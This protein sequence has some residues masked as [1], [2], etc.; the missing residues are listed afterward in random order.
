MF[1][2]FQKIL[3]HYFMGV[4]AIGFISSV[5]YGQFSVSISG[6]TVNTMVSPT[7][8]FNINAN[9]TISAPNVLKKIV[10]YRNDVPYKT[11]LNPGL[12]ESI[13]QDE[14]GQDTY[15]YKVRAYN[16][17]DE[18]VDSAEYKLIV[19]T[20][21]IL[22]MGKTGPGNVITH[23]T[24]ETFTGVIK[25]PSRYADHTEAIKAAIAYLN[26]K[27]GGTLYFPCS[28]GEYND[29]QS[30]Y[31]I[32][33]T[34][35]VPS[36][37]TI[38]GESSETSGTC[39]IYLNNQTA[40]GDQ[41]CRN[42]TENNALRGIPLFAVQGGAKNV[43]FRDIFLWSRT[44]GRDCTLPLNE[45]Q[46]FIEADK[47]V[48]VAL[49]GSGGNISDVIFENVSVSDFT[50]GIK[51]TTCTNSNEVDSDFNNSSS[52]PCTSNNDY[53]IRNVKIRGFRPSN[54]FRQ[55]YINAKYAYDWDI[56][57]FNINNML[58]NQGGVEIMKSGSPAVIEGENRSLKF[59][60]L[61]C[62]GNQYRTPAFCG[63]VKKHGG[64]YFRQLH[65][66]G[67][68]SALLVEDISSGDNPQTNPDP[69][70][71]EHGVATGE[72]K[73]PSMKLYLIGNSI[74]AAPQVAPAFS[75]NGRMR[76]IENG[77]N[78][79]LVDCGD[80]HGDYTDFD[81]PA[82]PRWQ[83]FHML[84]SHT[85]RNRDSFYASDGNLT[86]PKKHFVCPSNVPN[87]TDI[88]KVGGEFF[89][90]GVMPV[91]ST[92]TAN[93]IPYSYS[94]GSENCNNGNSETTCA[95]ILNKY[96]AEVDGSVPNINRGTVYIRNSVIIKDTIH[97]PHG[98][99]LFGGPN[100][101][102]IFETPDP[103][104]PLIQITAKVVD[105]YNYRTS[106]ISIRN[107]KLKTEGSNNTGLLIRGEDSTSSVGASSDLH[108][109][110]LIFEG[111]NKGM[112]VVDAATARDPMIDGLSWKNLT[113]INNQTAARIQSQN[114]SNW[115][116]MNVSIQSNA[117]NADGWYQ[118][119]GG[120]SMQNISCKGTNANYMRHCIKYDMTATYLTGFKPTEYVN[121]SL[122]FG[123]NYPNFPA[124]Y[125]ALKFGISVIRENDFR[126]INDNNVKVN[127]IG[128]TF[129]TSLNN[130][131]NTFAAG[132]TY[133]G[134]LSRVAYCGDT[135]NTS[136]FA[137]LAQ[138]YKNYYTGVPT[139]TRM[140]CGLRPK[141]WEAFINLG[142]EEEDKPFVGNFFSNVQEDIVIYREGAPS[143]FLIKS[144]D[145][146]NSTSI[147]WGL[148]ASN[149]D[150][151]DKPLVGNFIPGS[152]AQIAIWRPSTGDW[153]VYDRNCDSNNNCNP[154]GYIWHWGQEGDIPFVGNF[155]D[156]DDAYDMDEIAIYRPSSNIFWI[157]NPRTGEYR[158]IYCGGDFGTNIQVG[159]FFSGGHEQIA[160]YQVINNVGNWRIYNL[161]NTT[162]NI[163]T[164]QF[165]IAGDIPIPG[166]YLHNT[167][168][169]L[170]VWRHTI[171][172]YRWSLVA[173]ESRTRPDFKTR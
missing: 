130:K 106:G 58:A 146:K 43:R 75:D 78:A 114:L 6:P 119:T 28:G 147:D 49:Y 29:V 165:G 140:Q 23:T 164:L 77:Q 133:E 161:L 34:I 144:V 73:D 45:L 157:S 118:I 67:T 158:S 65:H 97:I 30:I 87:I 166:N 84:Y 120:N 27:G 55:L 62:N 103:T 56:Q 95:K 11:I 25:G 90:S 115:N 1:K 2:N 93:Q 74:T 134:N 31:N 79:T 141:P 122:T 128:K 53:E 88:N 143:K 15:I 54:N 137:G 139:A 170:A 5:A 162:L 35:T 39:R 163:N 63:R 150:K 91:W 38:Q 18:A 47:S 16:T 105:Q 102:L 51:A 24:P 3:L 40:F 36:N 160:Q 52:I 121:Y 149:P 136:A 19:E 81:N 113:F 46:S 37:V 153:W 167:Y 12:T 68:N 61:N 173:H 100:S 123:E 32:K 10:F 33:E 117:P 4:I 21:R 70:V 89:N 64:L 57:N 142:G 154:N 155:F 156:E 99:Q 59:L 169:Q 126:A 159:K 172:R 66:E 109:S 69:I 13:V 80:V 107:L 168:S 145:G 9:V 98:R 86:Y 116:V 76:F 108:F 20:P 110:G 125:T 129:L 14:L 94:F 17:L 104:K 22:I 71:F 96:L 151:R 152:R 131:Y 171:Y 50:Y 111:F 92:Q 26:G 148:T 60:Q 42:S 48:A 132:S 112:E 101:E 124:P 85:D 44:S 83:D 7:N 127:F 41:P 72:F 82:E 8:S 138:D 135:F